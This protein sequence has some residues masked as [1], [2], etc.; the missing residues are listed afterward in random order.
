MEGEVYRLDRRRQRERQLW[1]LGPL[2]VDGGGLGVM[3]GMFGGVGG[4]MVG[5]DPAMLSG[6]TAGLLVAGA[7]GA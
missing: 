7:A 2:R 3:G 1:R 4:G 5:M 6:G